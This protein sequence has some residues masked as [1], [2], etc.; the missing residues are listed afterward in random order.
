MD[1]FLQH[2]V[3]L[4]RK[5]ERKSDNVTFSFRS[6]WPDLAHFDRSWLQIFLARKIAKIFGK[7]FGPLWKMAL[8][9]SH[10]CAYFWVNFWTN[11]GDFSFQHLVTL[12][13]FSLSTGSKRK[14]KIDGPKTDCIANQRDQIGLFL[15]DLGDKFPYKSSPNIW[16][17]VGMLQ[18]ASL[19]TNNWLLWIPF[20]QL[21]E[22]WELFV[23]K[24]SHAVA[25]VT[26]KFVSYRSQSRIM[27]KHILLV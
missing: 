16:H 18:K 4:A 26:S 8:L 19:L 20:G 23:L 14:Q 10:N 1:T 9:K 3:T 13:P 5:R 27:S 25:N 6:V 7:L 11:L 24:S 15:N 17:R 22:K 2:L 21:F 12:V